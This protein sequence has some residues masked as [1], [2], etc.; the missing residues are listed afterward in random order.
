MP[1]DAMSPEAEIT[2]V[3]THFRAVLQLLRAKRPR[4]LDP[5]QREVRRLLLEEL[6]AY[7]ARGVFPQNR[8]FPGERRPTF[9]DVDGRHCAV[10]HLMDLSGEAPL[11]RSIAE[12]ANF[13]NVGELV[14]D[15]RVVTWLRTAGFTPEEIALVQPSYCDVSRSE[16]VCMYAG[17]PGASVVVL[18][19]AGWGYEIVEI[20]QSGANIVVGQRVPL[21]SPIRDEADGTEIIAQV[22]VPSPA[23]ADAAVEPFVVNRLTI[24]PNGLSETCSMWGASSLPLTKADALKALLSPTQRACTDYLASLDGAWDDEPNCGALG[25]DATAP[26]VSAPAS[27]AILAAVVGAIAARRRRA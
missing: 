2:A 24:L 27:L 17:Y 23:T 15:P 19:R 16:C 5:A 1:F 12:R 13:A 20:H 25:C 6:E 8:H 9:I 26:T 21:T 11:A 22:V 14:D 18:R 3:Q 4:G 7:A 10:A